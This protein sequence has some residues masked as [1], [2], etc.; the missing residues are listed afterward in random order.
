MVL[1]PAFPDLREEPVFLARADASARDGAREKLGRDP[2]R[3]VLEQYRPL[4]HAPVWEGQRLA[5]R[6]VMLRVVLAADGRGG[7]RA[8]AGGLTRIAGEDRHVVSGHRGGG[9]KETWIL[10]DTAAVGVS[11]LRERLRGEE[12]GAGDRVVSSRA[13]ENLFW[14]GRYAERTQNGARLSRA[15]LSRLPDCDAF[16][17]GLYELFVRACR[18][19]GLLAEPEDDYGGAPARLERE[20]IAGIF[21]PAH[22]QGVAFNIERTLRA[23]G[24]VRERLSGDNWRVLNRLAHS[25]SSEPERGA[26]LSEALELVDQA[27]LSMVAV[28]GLEMSH[29][30]RDEG[31]RFLGLGRL[32]E[33]LVFVVTTL[34]AA[35]STEGADDPAFLEWLLDLFDKTVTYR[36]SHL[37]APEWPTVMQLLLFDRRNPRSAVFQLSKLRH[38][39]DLL[40]EAGFDDLLAELS[41][42][43]AICRG[44]EDDGAGV[45]ADPRALLPFLRSCEK[46]GLGLSDALTLRYFSHA[47]EPARATAML[48]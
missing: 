29:M 24:A 30:T 3:Y 45:S 39:V 8:M 41:A 48:G 6:A 10:S 26:G 11:L 34:A 17:P 32:V 35:A 20:L 33:R 44:R 9:S 31:W 16:P 36:S 14:L 25:L 12:P 42:L 47:Y 15:V 43:T 18:A 4:S 40:P 21:D 13:G 38:Q 46:A 23:A 7:Y 19:G 1:K 37:R 27:I 22:G 5:S 28:A 2:A